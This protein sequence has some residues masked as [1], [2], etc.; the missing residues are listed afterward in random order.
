MSCRVISGSEMC[1]QT[2]RRAVMA[3]TRVPAW[4]E[5]QKEMRFEPFGWVFFPPRPF[6]P[7][8]PP[9]APSHPSTV[10]LTPLLAGGG[11]K[12]YPNAGARSPPR[13][14]SPCPP[15]SRARH[16]AMS[17]WARHSASTPSAEHLT[18]SSHAWRAGAHSHTHTHTH[19]RQHGHMCMQ[20]KWVGGGRHHQPCVTG[21]SWN[22]PSLP[23]GCG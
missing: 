8:F 5:R 16:T 2:P 21:T 18:P 15:C 4:E 22:V 13:L 12:S 23:T 17:M 19:S 11:M 6:H 9:A 3:H 20:R 1:L 14:A 7:S 10:T